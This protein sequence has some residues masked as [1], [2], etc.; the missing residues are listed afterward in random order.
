MREGKTDEKTICGILYPTRLNEKGLVERLVIDTT[1]QDE[2]FIN[3]NKKGKELL[4]YLRHNVE[5][6]GIIVEDNDGNF[7][8]NVMSY[9][10]MEDNENLKTDT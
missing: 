8:M 1:D 4:K 7:I 5:V 3:L 9:R 10:L 6:T 2:Y